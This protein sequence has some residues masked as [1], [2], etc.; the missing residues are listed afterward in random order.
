MSA[1]LKP[2]SFET[3]GGTFNIT[4]PYDTLG[5]ILG[6]MFDITGILDRLRIRMISTLLATISIGE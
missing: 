3:T 2:P 6:E 4:M 1:I 5:Y